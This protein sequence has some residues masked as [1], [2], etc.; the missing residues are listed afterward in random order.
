[1]HVSESTAIGGREEA[2]F[3]LSLQEPNSGKGVLVGHSRHSSHT[4]WCGV[5]SLHTGFGFLT[6][7]LINSE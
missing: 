4:F 5:V 6:D 2:L 7:V 1:M 3:D